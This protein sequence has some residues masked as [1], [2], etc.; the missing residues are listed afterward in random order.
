[1]LPSRPRTGAS[2][3][4]TV[5][6]TLPG[7]SPGS[8]QS[9]ELETN[10]GSQPGSEGFPRRAAWAGAAAVVSARA[11]G[12]SREAVSNSPPREAEQSL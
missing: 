11:G 1:M 4:H 9:V 8:A 12:P 7:P 10:K 2:P 5:P 3:L 6:Q